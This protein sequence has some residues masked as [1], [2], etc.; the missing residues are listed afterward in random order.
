M[1]HFWVRAAL[2]SL[3]FGLSA[4][5]DSRACAA[6]VSPPVP[7]RTVGGTLVVDSYL[8]GS[9]EV[10]GA[11]TDLHVVSR[12]DIV[13]SGLL[14]GAPGDAGHPQGVSVTLESPT[15][16]IILGD[17]SA[18]MGAANN[19]VQAT[20]GDGGKIELRAPVVLVVHDISGSRGGNGGPGGTGGTGGAVTVIGQLRNL[21]GT[22]AKIVGGRGGDGG[23]GLD[24]DFVNLGTANGMDGGNGG[25]GGNAD[26]SQIF[27]LSPKRCKTRFCKSITAMLVA[28]TA[29]MVSQAGLHRQLRA[30]LA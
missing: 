27:S 1:A 14:L 26:N 30:S 7:T 8:V 19:Q 18:G 6:V 2:A 29:A 20:G 15:R 5:I 23:I 25:A 3:A 11:Q 24:G 10:V 13:V 28:P 21:A 9:N 22:P 12:G 17:V 16:I 4:W